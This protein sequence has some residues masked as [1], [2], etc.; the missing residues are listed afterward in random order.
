VG[1]GRHA[2]EVARRQGEMLEDVSQIR[3]YIDALAPAK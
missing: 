2:L 1:R 3:S